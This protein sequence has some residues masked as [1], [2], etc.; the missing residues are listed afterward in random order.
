ML[1]LC[2][3]KNDKDMTLVK[4]YSYYMEVPRTYD[5]L[6]NFAHVFIEEYKTFYSI[7]VHLVGDACPSVLDF[8]V[9]KKKTANP[10]DAALGVILGAYRRSQI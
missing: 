2:I 7:T 6:N 8:R 10:K 3:N 5:K 4:T 1:Y 9:S